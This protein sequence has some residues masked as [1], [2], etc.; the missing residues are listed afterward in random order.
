MAAKKIELPG[1]GTSPN[2]LARTLK[3]QGL[4][5]ER[6][7]NA[8]DGQDIGKRY[9]RP[10]LRATYADSHEKFGAWNLTRVQMLMLLKQY[11]NERGQKYATAALAASK[12]TRKPKV[13]TEPTDS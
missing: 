4:L 1:E 13:A 5:Q 7:A 12:R 8:G 11:G 2:V 6:V 10:Y 3:S 9:F